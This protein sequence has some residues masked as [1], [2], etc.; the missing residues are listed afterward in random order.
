MAKTCYGVKQR[1]YHPLA[2]GVQLVKVILLLSE[3]D[4]LAANS[5]KWVL[6]AISS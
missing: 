4:V 1:A 3:S 6:T 5:C 2:V